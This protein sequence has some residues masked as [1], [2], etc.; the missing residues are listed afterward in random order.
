MY[1]KNVSI[2]IRNIIIY[3]RDVQKTAGFYSNALG[4]KIINQSTELIELKDGN[5]IRILLKKVNGQAIYFI[6]NS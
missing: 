6:F 4:L 1:S 5:N 2:F 3:S